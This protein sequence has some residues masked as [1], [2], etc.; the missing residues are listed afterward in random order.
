M[1]IPLQ[2]AFTAG[3]EVGFRSKVSVQLKAGRSKRN[4]DQP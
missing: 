1:T 2:L 3:M 4:A